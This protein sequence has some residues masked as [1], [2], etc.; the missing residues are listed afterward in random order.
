[1]I[2]KDTFLPSKALADEI[3]LQRLSTFIDIVYALIF[4]HMF[5]TYLPIIED[6]SWMAKPYGL[7]S[8]LAEKQ[9][10]LL[11]IFIGAGLALLYWNQTNTFINNLVKTNGVHVMLSLVQLILV[12]LFVYFA[13]ADPALESIS[14]PALQA[15]SLA[16]A[17]FSGIMSWRYAVAKGLVRPEL[18][19]EETNVIMDGSLIEPL[20]ATINVGLAFVGPLVWTFGWFVIPVIL[21]LLLKIKK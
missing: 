4:F 5:T 15:A 12:T 6:M 20:T 11:R 19:K 18:K 7:L 14:S 10:E 1:M 21:S 8:L 2:S 13:I 16:L 9:L 3:Y 17:G